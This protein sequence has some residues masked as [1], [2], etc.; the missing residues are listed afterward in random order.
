VHCLKQV[1]HLLSWR[2][3]AGGVNYFY[4]ITYDMLLY[5][6]GEWSYIHFNT[7]VLLLQFNEG[8]VLVFFCD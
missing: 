3:L 8:N 2:V 6:G 7:L 5:A 4:C 1:I